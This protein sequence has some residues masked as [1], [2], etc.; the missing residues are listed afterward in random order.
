MAVS[1]LAAVALAAI[2]AGSCGASAD[3]ATT[4]ATIADAGDGPD[5][6]W[7]PEDAW[8][9][10]DASEELEC[11]ADIDCSDGDACNVDLC[12]EGTCRFVGSLEGGAC[13]SEEECGEC[14]P[15]LY[16]GLIHEMRCF[17][18]C[19]RSASSRGGCDGDTGRACDLVTSVCLGGCFSNADCR[20]YEADL[21]GDG[22]WDGPDET[23]VDERSRAF[24][25]ERTGYCAQPASAADPDV[26]AGAPCERNS[27][28]ER[29]G[30]CVSDARGPSRRPDV[31]EASSRAW[32]TQR[33]GQSG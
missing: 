33:L 11:E 9:T 26:S 25:D 19:T 2:V 24:C 16:N 27:D 18:R 12:A 30:Y 6:A 22:V 14:G 5:D 28:C 17:R 13:R 15:C 7:S 1:R 21:D 8:S 10:E 20:W 23:L 32:R 31:G 29:D 4:D 3:S